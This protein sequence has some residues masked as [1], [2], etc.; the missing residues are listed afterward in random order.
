MDVYEV[1][2][3]NGRLRWNPAY[4]PCLDEWLFLDGY[5]MLS[6][7]GGSSLVRSTTKLDSMVLA[8]L[9]LGAAMGFVELLFSPSSVVIGLGEV[10]K[11]FGMGEVME[12]VRRSGVE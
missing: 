3:V 10:N 12:V 9:A 7:R 8:L 11:M 4:F 5:P 6:C 1:G 2:G